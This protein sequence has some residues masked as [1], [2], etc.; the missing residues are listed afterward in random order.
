MPIIM[1][2]AQPETPKPN[3]HDHIAE[4]K[5]KQA[6]RRAASAQEA[7]AAAAPG[8][9]PPPPPPPPAAPSPEKIEEIAREV[10][11]GKW[12]S[13]AERVEKLKSAGYDPD[14]VQKCVNQLL[15]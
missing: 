5:A 7:E 1:K 6:A 4:I 8:Q 15:K 3:N 2:D 14:A 9:N 10:I 11:A 13:G 12:S